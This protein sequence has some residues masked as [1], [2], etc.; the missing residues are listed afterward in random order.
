[1]NPFYFYFLRGSLTLC[2]LLALANS[3]R[4]QVPVFDQAGGCGVGTTP[5]SSRVNMVTADA[6]GNTYVV[7]QFNG[8]V[9][10]GATTLTET[11]FNDAFVA[12]RD[13]SGAWLWASGGG[14]GESDQFTDVAV[15]AQGQVYAVGSFAQGSR[16]VP[17]T[18]TFGGFTIT[19]AGYSDVLVAKLDGA[20]GAWLWVQQAGFGNANDGR[21]FGRAVAPDGAGGVLVAGTFDGPALR[22][23][24]TVLQNVGRGTD[25]FVARL[26]A[27]TGAWGWAVSTGHGTV[28]DLAADAQGNAYLTGDFGSGIAFSALFPLTQQS[29]SY[30]AKID[31]LGNWQ[32]ARNLTATPGTG[33]FPG[34]A[35]FTYCAGLATDNAGHLYACGKFSGG[36]A[37][38]GATTLT[39]TSGTYWPGP[40]APGTFQLGDAFVGR[41][42]A[43]TGGWQW[44]VRAGSGPDDEFLSQLAVRGNRVYAAGT[45]GREPVTGTPSAAGSTFGTTALVST[46]NEDIV[47]VALDTAG[48]PQWALRAGGGYQDAVTGLVLDANNRLH[49]AGTCGGAQFG[50]FTVT[51]LA[52]LARLSGAPLAARPLAG[53]APFALYPNPA[54]STVTVEG[55]AP[56][57]P[58]QLL[59]ALGRRMA[60]GHMPSHGPL[61]LVLPPALPPGMYVVR[62]GSQAHRLLVE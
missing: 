33:T 40:S 42:D 26:D 3:T 15:D 58:V 47:V 53:Q 21:D 4:A 52:Y 54:R 41:L 30:I 36:T 59:D 10:F 13:A 50:P 43:A 60:G 29:G 39:N 5:S 44:A 20:T 12:K 16:N 37:A 38:F 18:A 8:S 62:N 28:A 7:G 51:T 2:L 19:S 55:L 27:A 24:A 46:G 14:G 56:G 9:R 45:F 57:Q 17:V 49:L 25:L 11:G 23:G 61:H 34:G 32:W 1:M 22:V 48:A 31:R 6:Q 35:G